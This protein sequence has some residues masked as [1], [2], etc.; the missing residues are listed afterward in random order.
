MKNMKFTEFLNLLYEK[1]EVVFCHKD[2]TFSFE[3]SSEG[4]SE[5]KPL[6]INLYEIFD[7]EDGRCML[8]TK[9]VE[10]TYREDIDKLIDMPIFDGKSLLEIETEVVVV[11]NS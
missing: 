8:E 11:S 7:E 5:T 1:Q 6:T 4:L 10:E 2:K 3:I 9:F